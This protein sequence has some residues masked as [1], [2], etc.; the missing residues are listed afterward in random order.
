M[1][2]QTAGAWLGKSSGLKH[3]EISENVFC[4]ADFFEKD[5]T[6]LYF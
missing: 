3:N 4:G 1:G 2:Q 6:E 5:K